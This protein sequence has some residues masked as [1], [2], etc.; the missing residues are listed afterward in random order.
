VEITDTR[1][2]T[3][4]TPGSRLRRAG[5]LVLALGATL[6]LVAS[7]AAT[8]T[9]TWSAASPVTAGLDGVSCPSFGVCVATAGTAARINT[10][11]TSSTTWN[12]ASTGATHTLLAVSCAPET[13]VCAAV[14]DSGQIAATANAQAGASSSW[15][16]TTSPDSA[17]NLTS[18]SCPTTSFCLAVDNHGDAVYST[19][20]SGGSWTLVSGIDSTTALTSVSCASSALCAAT[21]ASGNILVSTTPTVSAPWTAAD[22]DVTG[23]GAVACSLGG[24][25]V[26]VTSTGKAVASAN[27]SAGLSSTWSDTHISSHALTAVNCTTGGLC[28][29][30]D[31]SGAVFESDVP[32]AMS[33]SWSTQSPDGV[34]ITGVSCAIDGVCAA[35]DASGD[36]LTATLPAPTVATG[37][38]TAASQTTATL[39]ATVTPSDATI[40]D[41]HFNYGT[42]TGYGASVP[43]SSTPS[44]NGGAQTVT[45]QISGLTAS[46]TYDFQV[47]ATSDDGTSSGANATLTTP[48]PLKAPLTIT[49]TPAVGDTLTCALGV[50]VPAG[51][52]VTYKWVRD[53][54]TIAGATG[55]TYVVALAD[56]SHHLYCGATVSGDGG[57]AT[58]SSGYVAVPAETLGTINETTITKPVVAGGTVTTTVTCSPQALSECTIS[59][60]LTTGTGRHATAIGSK[61]ERIAIGASLSV[62]V[63]VN[64]TGRNLIAHRH[65]V[66]ATLTVSGTIVGVIS[67]TIKKQSVVLTASGHARR[68]AARDGG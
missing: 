68:R 63:A 8:P 21:D 67:G 45:A 25:C 31:S 20:P 32:A 16:A 4:P 47:V 29:A 42:S 17:N 39:S 6:A 1:E 37:S 33:P 43:C 36:A 14:G 56:Q 38:G 22:S 53:T 28:V 40:T 46:T 11:P 15:S 52:T 50:S 3:R 51:L 24:T 58:S 27:P 5:A 59:L 35:V 7:A 26:A 57:S 10:S 55:G 65:H 30:G 23:V 49:G 54:T 61:T 9:L 64:A 41:C 12:A 2:R 60:R 34:A 13:T 48:A 18:V 19:S 44:P 62:S 66:K